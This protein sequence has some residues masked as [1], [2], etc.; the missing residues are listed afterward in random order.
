[1]GALNDWDRSWHSL[2]MG[3]PLAMPIELALALNYGRRVV[4]SPRP[5]YEKADY[6]F[7]QSV[8][9]DVM[10]ALQS[11][12][13]TVITEVDLV[14]VTGRTARIDLMGRLGDNPV[15]TRLRRAL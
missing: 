8:V 3:T 4:P 1:M 12:G 7:H 15:C 13:V 14:S 6:V 9:S 10:Q 2:A 11:T 5:G